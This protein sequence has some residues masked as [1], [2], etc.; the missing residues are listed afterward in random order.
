MLVEVA[1]STEPAT[2]EVDV[3]SPTVIRL[4]I[5][6]PQAENDADMGC[7]SLALGLTSDWVKDLIGSNLM[8]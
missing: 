8:D 4:S 6:A 3:I 5:R 7:I 1:G 2:L